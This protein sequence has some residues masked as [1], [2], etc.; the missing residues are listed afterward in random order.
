M[1]RSQ[2]RKARL[3]SLVRSVALCVQWMH[4]DFVLGIS[5]F[6]GRHD[7]SGL[8]NVPL[9]RLN[10]RV[11]IGISWMVVQMHVSSL[12]RAVLATKNTI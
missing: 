5:H 8:A 1:L 11:T 2:K 4:A 9:M 3:C 6:R 12:A 10:M 7:A